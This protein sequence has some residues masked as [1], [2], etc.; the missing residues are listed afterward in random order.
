[1]LIIRTITLT[2][3]EHDFLVLILQPQ[4]LLVVWVAQRSEKDPL[5]TW[6]V[7]EQ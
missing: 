3:L 7:I 1:M 6:P 5:I 4:L 2:S